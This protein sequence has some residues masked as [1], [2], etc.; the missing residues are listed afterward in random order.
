MLKA[1]K[2][3]QQIKTPLLK[4]YLRLPYTKENEALL[5]EQVFDLKSLENKS[6]FTPLSKVNIN[7]IVGSTP[8]TDNSYGVQLYSKSKNVPV[9]LSPDSDAII[10]KHITGNITQFRDDLVALCGTMFNDPNFGKYVKINVKTAQLTIEKKKMKMKNERYP[11][12]VMPFWCDTIKQILQQEILI[13]NDGFTD[14]ITE[15]F[16]NEGF[17]KQISQTIM[18]DWKKTSLKK[19]YLKEKKV[20]R[21]Q[22]L[23]NNA[24]VVSSH[25]LVPQ[26]LIEDMREE[27]TKNGL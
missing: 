4:T 12:N 2:V 7:T 17:M 27:V 14:A 23:K 25:S 8:T 15:D 19:L 1:E 6:P 21:Q 24:D 22:K 9:Y 5:S 26:S 13:K 18:A 10:I 3:K 11:V 16:N 20:K